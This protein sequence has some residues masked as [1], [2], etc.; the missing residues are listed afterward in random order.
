M[1]TTTVQDFI[2]SHPSPSEF[3]TAKIPRFSSSHPPATGVANVASK[4]TTIG[5]SSSN[6][7]Q[8]TASVVNLTEELDE[9]EMDADLQAALK[10]SLGQP[11]LIEVAPPTAVAESS[12]SSYH[13]CLNSELAGFGISQSLPS[14]QQVRSS[15]Y[16]ASTLTNKNALILTKGF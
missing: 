5:G 1:H 15:F 8:E 10:L 16:Q 7:D 3:R 2:G 14:D 12:S 6:G 11:D 9:D 13:S 4:S